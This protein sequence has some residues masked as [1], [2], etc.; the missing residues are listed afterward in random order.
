MVGN[1]TTIQVH[2]CVNQK[3]GSVTGDTLV[4]RACR[5]SWLANFAKAE[6]RKGPQIKLFVSFSEIPD[7][8]RHMQKS[9]INLYPKRFPSWEKNCSRKRL[10]LSPCFT[11]TDIHWYRWFRVSVTTLGSKER[12]RTS[13]FHHV[14]VKNPVIFASLGVFPSLYQ[15]RAKF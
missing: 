15:L 8:C 1:R 9:F 7:I 5:H 11:A 2:M 6:L 12:L 4:S 10:W 13:L 3:P 14:P